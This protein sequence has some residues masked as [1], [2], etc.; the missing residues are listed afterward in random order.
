MYCLAIETSCD[1]TSV[2]ILEYQENTDFLNIVNSTKVLSSKVSSQ[3]DTHALY[4]GVVP[5]VGARLHTTN[6]HSVLQS[7]VIDVIKAKNISED[8]FWQGTKLISVTKEPG[9][10]SALKV[11]LENAK[12]IQ[13]FVN[14]KY[15]KEVPI[16][17]VNHLHG[18]LA[19]SFLESNEVIEYNPFPHLHLLVSG[20]NTQIL[21]IRSWQEIEI[22]AKTVDD[23]VG[24]CFDKTARMLGFKYPGGASLAKIAGMVDSN[25]N[26]LNKAMIN[27]SMNTSFSGLKTQVRYICQATQDIGYVYE[28]LVSMEDR[29]I[30]IDSELNQLTSPRLKFIK[31]MCI[32]IQSICIEQ[33]IRK[34]M[35]AL[36]YKEDFVEYKSIGLSG[37]VSADLLLRKKIAD[38]SDL[39]VLIPHLKYTG[40]NA[41]MI[42]LAGIL[43]NQLLQKQK[44]ILNLQ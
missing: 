17:Y 24:E 35:L 22:I 12:A 33:L 40:D 10:Q 6:F 37:G 26:G 8:E 3:I 9:L 29:Q 36:N 44:T 38:M 7:C 5:E 21:R 1:D 14:T 42:G 20:G 43:D 2:A 30:M 4:G 28:E 34:M 25:P 19:S 23:A 13:Y 18:H 16:Q 15:N 11:G 39:K 31:S 27:N 32:S 41:A